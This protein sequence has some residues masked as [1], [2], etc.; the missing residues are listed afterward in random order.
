MTGNACQIQNETLKY[1][2]NLARSF[3]KIPYVCLD[4]SPAPADRAIKSTYRFLSADM[5]KVAYRRNRQSSIRYK[6]YIW[7]LPDETP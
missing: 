7:E 3:D 4:L 1:P 2:S 5:V 6:S